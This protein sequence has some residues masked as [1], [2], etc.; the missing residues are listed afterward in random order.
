MEVQVTIR[1]TCIKWVRSQQRKEA[2]LISIVVHKVRLVK[3]WSRTRVY[4]Q[5]R[6]NLKNSWSDTNFKGL[7]FQARVASMSL[8]SAWES[9]Q[10]LQLTIKTTRSFQQSSFSQ[11]RSQGTT[12]TKYRSAS[13]R[14][15][16]WT[17]KRLSLCLM[18]SIRRAESFSWTI[19]LVK[20]IE[21][22]TC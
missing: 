19:T 18:L 12:L 11:S 10:L 14:Y 2:Q 22:C 16:S 13:L 15:K 17:S 5:D 6:R 1:R 9:S 4:G 7:S 20:A 3:L 8:I 21:I